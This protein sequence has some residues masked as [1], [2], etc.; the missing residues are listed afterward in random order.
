MTSV[1]KNINRCII[2]V[3]VKI[4]PPSITGLQKSVNLFNIN[5]M[6]IIHSE[7]WAVCSVSSV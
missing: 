1:T 3:Y 4:T 7:R 5:R 6:Y 2:L